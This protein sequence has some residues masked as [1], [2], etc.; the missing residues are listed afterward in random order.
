MWEVGGGV[1]VVVG[2]FVATEGE[3]VG[4]EVASLLESLLTILLVTQVAVD[5]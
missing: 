4:T 3:V 1:I 2:V 5:C